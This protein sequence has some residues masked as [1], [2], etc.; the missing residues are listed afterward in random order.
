VAVSQD[1]RWLFVANEDAG[2]ARVIGTSDGRVVAT[3]AVGGEPGASTARRKVVY[4]TSEEDGRVAAVRCWRFEGDR[5]SRRPR[6]R[7]RPASCAQQ[8]A[9]IGAENGSAVTVVDA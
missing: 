6:G 5:P 9:Y 4:V 3:L 2:Q 1:R 8:R 7:A